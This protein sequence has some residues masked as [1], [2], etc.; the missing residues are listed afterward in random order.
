MFL[1]ACSESTPHNSDGNT[2]KPIAVPSE[3]AL[4]TPEKCADGTADSNTASDRTSYAYHNSI[5]RD[6]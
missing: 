5:R 2:A 1:Q 6:Q 4:V 3:A